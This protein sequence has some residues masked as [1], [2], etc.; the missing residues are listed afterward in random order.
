MSEM[1][2]PH[3]LL[4]GHKMGKKKGKEKQREDG[5]HRF[6]DKLPTLKFPDRT[7]NRVERRSKVVGGSV[8]ASAHLP[9]HHQPEGLVGSFHE[10]HGLPS[11]A[12][13]CDLIDVDDLIPGL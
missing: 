1:T 3:F 5:T 12:A 2:S 7:P 8:G 4:S 10:G 9:A 13:Q 11:G 6:K